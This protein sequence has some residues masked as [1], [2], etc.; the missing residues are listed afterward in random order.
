MQTRRRFAREIGGFV[1]ETGNRG[2]K[3]EKV[4]S[5]DAGLRWLSERAQGEATYYRSWYRDLIEP[6]AV[7]VPAESG[8]LFLSLDNLAEAEIAGLEL[9]Q[10]L[11]AG[12][13]QVQLAWTLQQA[14]GRDPGGDS[15]DLAG[16]LRRKLGCDYELQLGGT[17]ETGI[18]FRADWQE[19]Y[20]D[21]DLLEGEE[22]AFGD[23][24]E[25]DEEGEEAGAI[26][27]PGETWRYL[28]IGAG[29]RWRLKPGM[30][31]RVDIANFADARYQSVFGIPQPG[32]VATVGLRL[33]LE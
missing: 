3:P 21:E 18:S 30:A 12:R 2:L 29:A 24:D 22:G 7:R 26:G 31:L 20:F 8:D 23:D 17:P 6:A 13:S 1:G 32:L 5:A 4:W 28:V 27:A 25:D 11:R 16:R 9:V 19:R 10:R 33:D 14:S 15:R